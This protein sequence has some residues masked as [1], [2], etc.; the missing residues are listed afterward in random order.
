MRDKQ[1]IRHSDIHPRPNAPTFIKEC[2]VVKNP[3]GVSSGSS[4][5]YDSAPLPHN[6]IVDSIGQ[7]HLRMISCA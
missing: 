2:S 3:C 6:A 4:P 7:I 5:K 1:N